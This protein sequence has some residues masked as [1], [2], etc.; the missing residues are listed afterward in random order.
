MNGQAGSARAFES[1]QRELEAMERYLSAE[2][3]AFAF[4]DVDRPPPRQ[5]TEPRELG[6]LPEALRPRA[7]ALLRAT[8]AFEGEVA[9][10][11][12]SVG[13]ALRHVERSR[14]VVAAYVDE[15]A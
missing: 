8:R 15:R 11:R 12:A 1:W 7:E 5:P 4:R 6:P 2:R 3:E 10:A 14:P 9:D 13:T